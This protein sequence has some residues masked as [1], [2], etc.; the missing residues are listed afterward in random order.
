MGRH[1]VGVLNVRL[2]RC[3]AVDRQRLAVVAGRRGHHR[4]V[5]VLLGDP[6]PGVRAAAVRAAARSGVLTPDLLEG[7]AGDP[8]PRVRRAALEVA[9]RLPGAPVP[10]GRVLEDPDPGVRETAAWACGERGERRWVPRLVEVARSDRD[11]LVREA[12]VAALGAI[13]DPRA[14][15][16]LAAAATGDRP[17]VRRRAVVALAAFDDPAVEEVLTRALADRDWQVRQLA[18]DLLDPDR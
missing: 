18:E 17:A 10:W 3:R 8:D 16:T 6:D 11:P 15:P 12:A 4:I 5:G 9:A 7:A 13:G 1:P 14:L 2:S